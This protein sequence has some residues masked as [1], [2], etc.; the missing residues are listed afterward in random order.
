MKRSVLIAIALI[1]IA[2]LAFAQAGSIGLFADSGG[3]SCNFSALSGGFIQ[4]HY[5]HLNANATASQFRL[6]IAGQPWNFFGDN[7]QF[8][9]VIGQSTNGVSIGYGGCQSAP[10]YL[11]VTSFG[12]GADAPAC[13]MI[14][15]VPDPAAL[16]GQIE[17]VD[18]TSTKV[19]P[20]GGAGILNS[21]GTCDCNVPVEETTWG[22]VK[23][24]YQ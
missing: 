2:S 6:D 14:S 5:Y 23:A 12:V 21:D 22:G 9:T 19:F 18:C 20:T 3:T 10:I 11:G 8:A 16:S 1:S 7:W 24:L 4:I 15:I 17:A 13:T